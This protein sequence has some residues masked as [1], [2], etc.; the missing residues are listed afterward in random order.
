M[1]GTP[2]PLLGSTLANWGG[3]LAVA[4][5]LFA[6]PLW[7][8]RTGTPLTIAAA[9]GIL[10]SAVGIGLWAIPRVTTGAFRQFIWSDPV[11]ALALYAAGMVVLGLQ[12]AGPVFGYLEYGLVSPL[13]VGVAATTLVTF[14]FFQI[15]G[16]TES[17]SL[18]V[19]VSPWVLGAILTV[20]LLETGVRRLGATIAAPG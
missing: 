2:D 16:E 11:V 13:A 12:V 5:V 4:L 14:L 9:S 1:P 3:A 7:Y 18:Y 19:L 20:A 17:F 15:G 8:R 10:A 6:G